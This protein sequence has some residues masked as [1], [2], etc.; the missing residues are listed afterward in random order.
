MSFIITLQTI[1]TTLGSVNQFVYQQ[2]KKKKQQIK[3]LL[4]EFLIYTRNKVGLA[5]RNGRA[6]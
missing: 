1:A 3:N 4:N 6:N 5:F 2:Q